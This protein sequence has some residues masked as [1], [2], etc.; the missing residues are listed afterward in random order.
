LAGIDAVTMMSLQSTTD[1]GRSL[2]GEALHW[3]FPRLAG[4]VLAALGSVLAFAIWAVVY[5]YVW[6]GKPSAIETPASPI[7]ET[8][9]P[10]KVPA[11][12]P[13]PI[14]DNP[15]IVQL[16]P[17]ALTIAQIKGWSVYD[18]NNALIGKIEDVVVSPDGK[19]V[20]FILG[21]GGGFLGG[22]AKDIAVP[23]QAVQF[24]KNDDSTWKPVLRMSKD[25]VKNAPTYTFDPAATKWMPDPAR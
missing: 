5:T 7:I 24:K 19:G 9:A 1:A 12:A 23:P 8:P 20:F 13:V 16:P 6:P 3:A 21:I 4:Y 15:P 17:D 18:A 2:L 25:A 10:V 11:P 14:D 22:Q